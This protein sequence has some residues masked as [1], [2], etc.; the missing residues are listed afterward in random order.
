MRTMGELC[1]FVFPISV[2]RLEIVYGVSFIV[3]VSSH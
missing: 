2:L 3:I 1:L